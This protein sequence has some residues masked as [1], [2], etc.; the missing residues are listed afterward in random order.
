MGMFDTVDFR[1]KCPCCGEEVSEFQ[2]KGGPCLLL[3]ISPAEAG[4]FY[5]PCSCGVWV[6]VTMLAPP[7]EGIFQV[8]VG[9]SNKV[10]LVNGLGGPLQPVPDKE[11]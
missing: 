9:E 8:E 1:T 11:A 6:E 2:S 10:T 3:V 4:H 7:G 5:G